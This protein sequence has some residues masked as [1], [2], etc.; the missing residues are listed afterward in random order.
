MKFPTPVQVDAGGRSFTHLTVATLS[1]HNCALEGSTGAAYCWVSRAVSLLRMCNITHCDSH[2]A[3]WT[4]LHAG[5][6]LL[7]AAGQW[8]PEAN[9]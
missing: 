3:L 9:G 8:S 5:L 4:C 1:S 2:F 6:W 7:R